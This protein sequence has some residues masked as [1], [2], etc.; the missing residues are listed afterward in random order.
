MQRRG[1]E[2]HTAG[3]QR[4]VD[5]LIAAFTPEFFARVRGFGLETE[6][7]VFIMGLP[8]SGTTL[9]AQ[10]LASHSRVFVAGELQFY[11]EV[12]AGLPKA[13]GRNA[14]P[15]ECLPHLDRRV[16]RRLAAQVLKRLQAFD[17]G[18]LRIVDKLPANYLYLGLI[19]V[20]FPRAKV[21]H[22]RRDLR[23]VALSCWTTN[24]TLIRWACDPDRIAARFEDHRRLMDHWSKAPPTPFLEV[25]YESVVEDLEGNA[26]RIIQ[27][28]GLEWEP[29][30][31]EFYKTRRAIHTASTGQVRQPIYRSSVGRWKNYEK[32][33]GPLFAKLPAD[34]R[35]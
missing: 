2:Y 31:L 30:C 15:F 12:F 14:T 6:L 3:E 35:T 20:L 9:I 17:P 7:P 8:R 5:A 22:C 21:I 27:W 25:D 32:L 13:V 29:Q 11:G 23:D 16:T 1:L 10:I 24:F 28:C 26:R 19:G 34:R 33:L 18:A 4:F